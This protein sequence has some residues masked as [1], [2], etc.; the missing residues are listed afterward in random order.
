MTQEGEEEEEVRQSLKEVSVES[1]TESLTDPLL[2]EESVGSGIKE[3][4]LEPQL[5]PKVEEIQLLS[6]PSHDSSPI[7]KE[8]TFL[9]S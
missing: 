8:V 9:I 7:P 5:S 1:T 2:M 4:Q 6:P 3:C